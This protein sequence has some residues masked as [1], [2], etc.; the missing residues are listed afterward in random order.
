M[1]KTGEIYE[2]M[3]QFEKDVKSIPAYSGS[4][5]REA[6]GESGQ[7]E[8]YAYYCDGQT[9]VLFLAYLWGHAHGRCYERNQ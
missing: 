2:I 5:T 3:A 9:N 1:Y 4:L 6:K 7:W 8:H